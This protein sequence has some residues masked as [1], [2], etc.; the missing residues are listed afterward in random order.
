MIKDNWDMIAELNLKEE[1][2]VIDYSV[3]LIRYVSMI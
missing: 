1:I 3:D 2:T